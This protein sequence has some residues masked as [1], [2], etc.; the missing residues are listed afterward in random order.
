[1]HFNWL[2]FIDR[3]NAQ[4]TTWLFFRVLYDDRSRLCYHMFFCYEKLTTLCYHLLIGALDILQLNIVSN[5]E[6][7]MQIANGVILP[8]NYNL[9]WLMTNVHVNVPSSCIEYIKI[10]GWERCKDFNIIDNFAERDRP[11]LLLINSEIKVFSV[12]NSICCRLA[13]WERRTHS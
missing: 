2:Q 11:M 8:Y 5:R 13:I 3:L 6:F 1:M 10:I 7:E 12:S 9:Q 4:A